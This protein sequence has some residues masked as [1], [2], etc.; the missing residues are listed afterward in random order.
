MSKFGTD[1][2]KEKANKQI[3]KGNTYGYSTKQNVF[4]KNT[5]RNINYRNKF[6]ARQKAKQKLAIDKFLEKEYEIS[7]YGSP[8]MID[9]AEVREQLMSQ[10]DPTTNTMKGLEGFNTGKPG[11]NFG[12]TQ[13]GPLGLKT[14]NNKGEKLSTK[15]MDTTPSLYSHPSNMPSIY[16]QLLGKAMPPNINNLMS[17]FNKINQLTDI[18]KD[19]VTQTEIDD[20][21]D[22]AQGKGKYNIFGGSE[23][24]APQPYLPIN[25]NTGAATIEG[26]DYDGTNQFTYD[27]NAFGP[28]GDSADVTRASYNFNKGGRAGKAEGGIMELRARRAF[29]GIMDRVTGRKAYGLGSIFKSVGKAVSGVAKAAGKVLKSDIGKAALLYAGGAYLGGSTMMGGAGGSFK[30]RMQSPS[31]LMNLFKNTKGRGIFGLR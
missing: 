30:S 17:G 31:N 27:E 15:Y 6:A 26:S 25:Y 9:I 21:Y 19:G 11:M 7:K 2:Q 5:T 16:G 18:Q 13:L 28:G 8:R 20:Y 1:K 14:T 4:T 10:Y 22:K 29:G 12:K 23:K 24:D 3:S